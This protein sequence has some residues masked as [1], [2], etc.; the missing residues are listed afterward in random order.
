MHPSDPVDA[1][2]L[3][4]RGRLAALAVLVGVGL[5]WGATPL[6]AK[7]STSTG[8]TSIALSAWTTLIGLVVFLAALRVRG[9]SLPVS[10]RHA[11]FYLVCGFVGTALPHWLSYESIRHLPVGIMAISLSTVPMMTFGLAAALGL[12]RPDRARLAG[13][14]LGLAAMLMIALPEASLPE[15][16]QAFWLALPMLMAFSYAVENVYIDLAKPPRTSALQVMAGLTLA[17]TLMVV[18]AHLA[19]SPHVWPQEA[20]AAEAALVASAFLH[21][22]AYFGFVWLIGHAGPVYAAQVGYVVTA[23]GILWGMAVL[24]ERHAVWIWAALVLLF[25]GLALV[26]PREGPPVTPPADRR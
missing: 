18:P 17:A 3:G 4:R 10:R 19:T 7:V 16:G 26:R 8:H 6:L 22:C 15:P 13:L 5:A 11:V 2:A 21:V 23:S 14:L 9:E 24:G 1:P 12:E 25:I 20:G